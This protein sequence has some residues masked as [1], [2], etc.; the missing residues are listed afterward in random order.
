[1][2]NEAGDHELLRAARRDPEAFGALAE[3]H[4][5]GL[6]TWAYGQ[7]RELAVANDV[8]AETLARAWI[9]RRRYRGEC[10]AAARGWLFGI[11]RNVVREWRRELRV[12]AGALR[13]MGVELP[14]PSDD[15]AELDERLSAAQRGE[16]LWP[17]VDDL[18]SGQREALRLRILDGLPYDEAAAQL[19][20]SDVATRML[21]S[22]ALR[23]L[24][25]AIASGEA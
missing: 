11:A 7:T 9:K 20:R 1:L 17:M 24:R 4:L 25:S 13:R 6:R 22:R 15:Q 14:P 16:E 19:G 23:R 2:R 21:V 12:E 18:P 10:D 5:P 3:R 8:A